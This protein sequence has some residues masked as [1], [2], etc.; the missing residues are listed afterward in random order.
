MFLPVTL[1]LSTARHRT[2]PAPTEVTL[3]NLQNPLEFLNFRPGREQERVLRTIHRKDI[4]HHD[5]STPSTPT[6]SS[7]TTLAIAHKK[8]G[9]IRIMIDARVPQINH[10]DLVA[11]GDGV[12]VQVWNTEFDEAP[13]PLRVGVVGGVEVAGFED[14][15][16][17]GDGGYSGEEAGLGWGLRTGCC[18]CNDTFRV[19]GGRGRR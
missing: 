11:V 3:I 10:V 12:D 17:F 15:G 19:G 8:S 13:D 18:G 9:K 2:P 6:A 14:R 4:L 16:G 1:V 5:S 7:T